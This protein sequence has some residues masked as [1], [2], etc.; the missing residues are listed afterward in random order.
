MKEKL[1][2]PFA[3]KNQQNQLITSEVMANHV[4]KKD[5]MAAKIKHFEIGQEK[6]LFPLIRTRRLRI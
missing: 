6:Y 3:I 1:L 5:K 2:P 4:L